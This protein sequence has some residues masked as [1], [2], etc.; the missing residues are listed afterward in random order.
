[1]SEG[2]YAKLTQGVNECANVFTWCPLTDWHPIQDVVLRGFGS[3]A[4][5]SRIKCFLQM[6]ERVY[7]ARNQYYPHG[8][9]KLSSSA[10]SCPLD[11]MLRGLMHE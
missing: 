10:F 2:G 5:Q 6:A 11:K 3:T 4:T 7:I 8:L 1:M 9:F